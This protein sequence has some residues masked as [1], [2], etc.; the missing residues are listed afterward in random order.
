MKHL[1]ILFL[2]CLLP[3][4]VLADKQDEA[5]A[6]LEK[7]LKEFKEGY[8]TFV[9]DM[10][11]YY[12]N[13]HFSFAAI[14]HYAVAGGIVQQ[15]V[16]E[17]TEI[18]KLETQF[19]SLQIELQNNPTRFNELASQVFTIHAQLSSFELAARLRARDASILKSSWL[20]YCYPER[21]QQLQRYYDPLGLFS[22]DSIIETIPSP[23]FSFE[24]R[25]AATFG[26]NGEL[27]G[28]PPF[29]D[30]DQEFTG[31]GV[32]TM[33]APACG[34]GAPLCYA[35]FL[36]VGFVVD[37]IVAGKKTG[38]VVEKQQK[39]YDLAQAIYRHQVDVLKKVSQV[40]IENTQKRCEENFQNSVDWQEVALAEHAQRVLALKLEVEQFITNDLEV[41]KSNAHEYLISTY[42][43]QVLD[44]YLSLI[45]SHYSEQEKLSAE[46]LVHVDK[47]FK[48]LLTDW[49]NSKNA[50][51]KMIH[52][53][54]LWKEVILT[55]A[56]Y[57]EEEGFSFYALP[58]NS[59]GILFSNIW[60]QLGPKIIQE[61]AK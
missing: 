51:E 16:R 12:T 49:Q 9:Q 54:T 6:K 44:G 17:Q 48:D 15:T 13:R 61:V 7:Q 58:T 37:L 24:I 20:N 41:I 28:L 38:K 14:D 40:S 3:L 35:G 29:P 19:R 27:Q 18:Q 56:L 57:L 25:I 36:A 8:E 52:Q 23:E 39:I 43:P 11:S 21:I 2:S 32:A 5:I 31:S 4:S 59:E 26:T 10:H 50:Q 60:Q 53:D 34:P 22:P 45:Q 30:S 42:I 33:L 55:D 47:T 46:I 1:L